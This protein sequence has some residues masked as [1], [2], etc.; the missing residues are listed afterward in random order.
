[1][2]ETLIHSL[3]KYNPNERIGFDGFFNHEFLQLNYLPCA[4]NYDRIKALINEGKNLERERKFQEASDKC[5]QAIC[6]LEG[7]LCTETN[8]DQKKMVNQKLYEYQR[9]SEQ[10]TYMVEHGSD[11]PVRT[12]MISSEMQYQSL[13]NLCK[14]TPKIKN[15][16]DI[17][18]VAEMYVIDGK[19]AIAL[20][21]I[22]AALDVLIPLITTEP[23]GPR[24]EMLHKQI[25]QWLALGET[26]KKSL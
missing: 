24:K 5:K 16:L 4:E 15:A 1:M 26:L 13:Y 8:A 18:R 7:F 10:L 6:F 19:L 21:K 23:P 25:Q 17:G 9:W 14:T 20:D 22:T 3:L 12:P 11:K 2:C